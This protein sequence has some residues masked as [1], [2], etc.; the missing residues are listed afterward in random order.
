MIRRVAMSMSLALTTR[1]SRS[2]HQGGWPRW[3]TCFRI[4]DVMVRRGVVTA[5]TFASARSP[6][7]Q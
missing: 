5:A 4:S 6:I 2:I 3:G 7:S 1:T